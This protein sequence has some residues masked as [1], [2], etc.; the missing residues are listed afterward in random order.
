MNHALKSVILVQKLDHMGNVENHECVIRSIR[1]KR[2]LMLNLLL[3]SRRIRHSG[4]NVVQLKGISNKLKISTDSLLPRQ[5]KK[6]EER[7]YLVNQAKDVKH[8]VHPTPPRANL[9]VGCFR[10]L[11]TGAKHSRAEVKKK[12]KKAAT[13]N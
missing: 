4:I 11:T 6:L 1:K 9:K 12:T 3:E 2:F 13:F 5:S 8:P 7:D 10:V